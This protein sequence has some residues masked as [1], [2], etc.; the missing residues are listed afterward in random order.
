MQKLFINGFNVSNQI[1]ECLSNF[2]A[3]KKTNRGPV[4]QCPL[5]LG[6]ASKNKCLGAQLAPEKKDSSVKV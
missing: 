4:A 6:W 5:F 2:K 1:G 3:G